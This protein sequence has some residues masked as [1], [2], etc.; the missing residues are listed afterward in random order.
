MQKN[1]SIPTSRLGDTEKDLKWQNLG[2]IW[3]INLFGFI[4]SNTILIAHLVI[5]VKF[6][7]STKEIKEVG[8]SLKL[9]ILAG[10]MSGFFISFW[11]VFNSLIRIYF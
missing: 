6:F 8:K 2:T 5:S 1:D 11:W 9:S 7:R 3:K 4:I 10:N